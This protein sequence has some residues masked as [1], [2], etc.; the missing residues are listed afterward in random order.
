MK[1]DVEEIS[2]KIRKK[3]IAKKIIKD[4]IYVDLIF[5]FAVNIILLHQSIFQ[6]DENKIFANIYMF[7]I[8]SRKHETYIK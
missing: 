2:N 5:I 7:N 8:V 1:Y 4:I 6:K 3:N